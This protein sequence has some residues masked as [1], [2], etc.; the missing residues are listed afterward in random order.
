[1]LKVKRFIDQVIKETSKITW[2]TR[3]ETSVSVMLVVVMVIIASLFFLLV[4]V[5]AYKVVQL[6]LNL[7]VN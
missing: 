4:D 2:S 5:G 7:G 3:K 6:L 1:M